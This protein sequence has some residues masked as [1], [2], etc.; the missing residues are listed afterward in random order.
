MKNKILG[1]LILVAVK[2]FGWGALGHR[3]VGIIAE[4]NLT[5]KAKAAVKY[6]LNNESLGD[7]ANWADAIKSGTTYQQTKTYH[8]EKVP[9]GMT[10]LEYLQNLKPEER[11][12]GGTVEAMFVARDIL[13]ASAVNRAVTAQEKVDAL[14]F[15]AHFVG[16]IH[17]PLHSGRP[18]DRG[19][20]DIKVVWAGAPLNLHSVWDGG[21]IYSGHTDL[22]TPA[23][24]IDK[25]SIIYGKFLTRVNSRIVFERSDFDTW[26]YESVAIRESGV[27]DKS[28]QTNQAVYQKT[29][30]PVLDNRVLMAGLRL[31]DTLNQ[32]FENSPIPEAELT[33]RKQVEMIVGNLYKFISLRPQPVN[34]RFNYRYVDTWG[35]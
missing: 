24:P 19:G 13:R 27:Y 35:H 34:T 6:L 3:T 31:A 22:F 26:V 15:L 11:A 12:L 10:Y 33:F 14:K 8:Y 20:N 18:E 17:Q 5:P 9:T 7:A 25:A 29:M 23:T 28:Y 4:A 21:M 30:L 1:I 16:D 32:I 2:S